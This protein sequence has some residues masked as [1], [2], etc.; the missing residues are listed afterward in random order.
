MSSGKLLNMDKE[1]TLAEIL[2]KNLAFFMAKEGCLYGNANSLGEA[3]KVSPG[4]VRNLLD[5]KK[6]T[7]TLKK[8]E[9]FPQLD[10]VAKLA[11]K[12]NVEVWELFHPDIKKS[13]RERAMY[14]QIESSFKTKTEAA[15]EPASA[16]RVSRNPALT[17]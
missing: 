9:G 4:S 14:A 15:E 13:L 7:V 10:T 1:K 17:R 3:A 5:P 16:K 6:R 8:P 11:Q 2:A 12:L